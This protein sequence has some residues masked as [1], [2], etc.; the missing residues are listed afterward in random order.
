HRIT[1]RKHSLAIDLSVHPRHYAQKRRLTRSVKTDHP[2]FCSIEVG[3][4]DVF[5]NGLLIIVLTDTDHRID[6]FIGF[7]AHRGRSFTSQLNLLP[8]TCQVGP[9]SARMGTVLAVTRL[10]SGC[11]LFS[12]ALPFR[13]SAAVSSGNETGGDRSG[14]I[15][16]LYR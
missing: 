4:I 1:R 5:K 12:E 9:D 8:L 13:A 16:G 6:D 3:K 15:D 14:F 2:D 10:R 7:C 11:P